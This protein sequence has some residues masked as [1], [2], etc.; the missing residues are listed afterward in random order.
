MGIKPIGDNVIGVC[1][2]PV[3]MA[4]PVNRLDCGEEC[5]ERERETATLTLH[6]LHSLR[7]ISFLGCEQFKFARLLP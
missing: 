2:L 6:W 3:Q 1:Q 5:I 4:V 7:S